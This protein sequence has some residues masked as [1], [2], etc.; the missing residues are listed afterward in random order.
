MFYR[1]P[2]KAYGGFI[3]SFTNPE[4]RIN[5]VQHNISS[6]LGLRRI[7]SNPSD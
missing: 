1:H 6:L 3:D 5:Y 2:D 4:I 7:L